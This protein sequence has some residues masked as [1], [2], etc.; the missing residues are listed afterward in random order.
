M[1]NI[2]ML[3]EDWEEIETTWALEK[4]VEAT[5]VDN[6]REL[7]ALT[8]L[9]IDR[10]KNMKRVLSFPR[11]WQEKVARGEMKF[12]ALVELEK[13]VLS[14]DP[15]KLTKKGKAILE[16]SKSELRDIFLKKY[17]SGAESD[18]VELRKVGSLIDTARGE[19]KVARRAQA[20]L[21]KLVTKPEVTI[22]EAYD[23][24]AASSVELSKVLRDLNGLPGRVDDLLATIKEDDE[25]DQVVAA[26]RD[27]VKR[28]QRSLERATR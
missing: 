19:G 20:A 10:I 21:T 9:S 26:L 16:V 6:D 1:F 17:E 7:H 22:E 18:I 8:G 13:N 24:G 12:Q 4:I 2:H 23:I 14:K 15:G 5:G 3:R 25:R 27:V 28:L 11:S